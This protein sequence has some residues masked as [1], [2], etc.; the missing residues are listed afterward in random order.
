MIHFPAMERLLSQQ[1]L[2]LFYLEFQWVLPIVYFVWQAQHGSYLIFGCN[3]NIR[4]KFLSFH[5]LAKSFKKRSLGAGV[6]QRNP[7]RMPIQPHPSPSLPP[8]LELEVA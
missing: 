8:I 6:R 7:P 5:E 1:V 3:F 2:A 4:L